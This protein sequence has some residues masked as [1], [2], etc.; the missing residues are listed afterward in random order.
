MARAGGGGIV[1]SESCHR[2]LCGGRREEEGKGNDGRLAVGPRLP[3]LHLLEAECKFFLYLH[4]LLERGFW[5]S[6]MQKLV[7]FA[8]TSSI[9]YALRGKQ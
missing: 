5:A 3:F 9:G 4:H 1:A 8:S 2:R 6:E 7:I